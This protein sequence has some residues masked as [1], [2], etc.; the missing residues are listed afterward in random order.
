ML[1]PTDFSTWMYDIILLNFAMLT[2]NQELCCMMVKYDYLN[3][4]AVF[5]KVK[6]GKFL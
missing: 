5:G 4:S 6:K 1:D 3:N 2:I